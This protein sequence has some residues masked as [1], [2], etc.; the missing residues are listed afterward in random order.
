M[1]QRKGERS[2]SSRDLN[3]RATE[4]KQATRDAD[5]KALAEGR[6]TAQEI[7]RKNSIPWERVLSGRRL[8]L[9]SGGRLGK[10]RKKR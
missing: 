6:M 4:L 9:S 10:L 8:D 3:A 5:Q 1:T 2:R 7:N